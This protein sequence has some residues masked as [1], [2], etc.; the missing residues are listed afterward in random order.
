MT[1]RFHIF[2]LLMMDRR[3]DKL[4]EL[5]RLVLQK[6]LVGDDQ[7]LFC[8]KRGYHV[9]SPSV[10]HYFVNNQLEEQGSQYFLVIS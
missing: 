4:G 1:P 8:Y 5:L 9:W 2:E 3:C 6:N 7:Y 10:C